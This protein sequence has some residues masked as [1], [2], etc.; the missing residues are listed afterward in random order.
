VYATVS[1][2]DGK[3]TELMLDAAFPKDSGD[4]PL[5]AVVYI[6]GGGWSGGHRNAGLPFTVAFA[7]GGYVAVTISY[8]LSGEAKY[9][10]AVHDCKAAIRFLRANADSLGIDAD[11]IGVWGHSAGG[12]LSAM[13][14]L[15]GDDSQLEGSV[16]E[17]DV[18]SKV[19]CFVSVC[20]PS[21]LVGWSDHNMVAEFLGGADDEQRQ[22][23]AVQ[24]SP[25]N[26]VDQADPPSLLVHGD[27][28]E[29][30]NVRHAHMLHEKL[31]SAG[32]DVELLVIKGAGHSIREKEAYDR[33]A[34]FFDAQLGGQAAKVFSELD[35]QRLNGLQ[36]QQQPMRRGGARDGGNAP[37][38]GQG[39][40]QG[41]G[42]RRP[43]AP[44]EPKSADPKEPVPQ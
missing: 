7:N 14:G 1:G 10:A 16:G 27:Q 26:H 15:T 3:E 32:A 11:R 9:P 35:W 38:E 19:A 2:A 22:R 4:A 34:A 31:Q 33:I 6:H 40:S 25:V 21:L 13:M 42:N 5:P 39:Q 17:T 30:V 44:N 18:S 28:D 23:L 41:A 29:L 8:R 20:G 12:H 36:P 43:A 24:A 37:R